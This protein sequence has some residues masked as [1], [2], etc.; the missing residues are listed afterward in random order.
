VSALT[1]AALITIALLA[2]AC[3]PSS[4][5]ASETV[6]MS[7]KFTPYH[8]LEHTTVHFG[9]QIGT[10]DG[11]VPSP[12][13][14]VDVSLPAGMG[15]E[16]TSL[17]LATCDTQTLNIVGPE[18]CSPDAVM[19]FGHA[20]AE[21]QVGPEIIQEHA[22]ITTMM[23]PTAGGHTVVLYY[24]DAAGPASVQ[25]IF[26]GL[27]LGASEPFGTRINTKVPVTGTWP[28]GPYASVVNLFASIGPEHLT[29]YRPG[30]KLVPFTPVGMQIPPKC[31]KGGFPFAATLAFLDGSSVN[32]STAIPCPSGNTG[33][34]SAHPHRH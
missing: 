18:G 28:G 20:L 25:L 9:F 23:A 14:N 22:K 27:V 11:T 2:C 13:T 19:G 32:T 29:Y 5:A 30:H 17:G 15:L 21:I 1:R 8:L 10:T 3:L 34:H 12:M 31:P 4:A 33:K 24:V 6:A 16:T 7:A 26:P